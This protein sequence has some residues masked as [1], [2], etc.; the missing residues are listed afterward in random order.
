[1]SLRVRKQLAG[2]VK[3]VHLEFIAD[4]VERA[5]AR[6]EATVNLFLASKER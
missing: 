4:F 5:Q 2:L 3:P 6:E 1:M